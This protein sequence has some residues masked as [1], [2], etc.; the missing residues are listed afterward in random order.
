MRCSKCG[1]QN[2]K[3][4]VYCNKCGEHIDDGF[5]ETLTEEGHSN[6]WPPPD[7]YLAR[8]F[9]GTYAYSTKSAAKVIYSGGI[10]IIV[11]GSLLLAI[12]LGILWGCFSFALLMPWLYI[13][14]RLG[15]QGA[16]WRG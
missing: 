8:R 10:V 4:S 13:N 5:V 3:E 7:A 6:P 15:R 9:L 11:V 14:W 1:S 16:D 2:P 12:S